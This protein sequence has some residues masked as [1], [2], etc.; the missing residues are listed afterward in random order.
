MLKAYQHRRM[1]YSRPWYQT[2]WIFKSIVFVP[3]P[4]N[5][6]KILWVTSLWFL[7]KEND[8]IFLNIPVI[9][10]CQNILNFIEYYTIPKIIF[11]IEDFLSKCDQSCSRLWIWSSLPKKFLMEN[12]I[13][14]VV[15]CNFTHEALKSFHFQ[16][17]L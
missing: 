4:L 5:C 9:R 12:L 3:L 14:C 2:P 7:Q 11:S 13:F 17:G 6:F 15:L 10:L 16:K 1:L 8:H